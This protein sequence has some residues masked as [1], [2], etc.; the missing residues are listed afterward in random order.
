MY[1]VM[2]LPSGREI[3]VRKFQSGNVWTEIPVVAADV[4]FVAV[5]AQNREAALARLQEL[6][7]IPASVLAAVEQAK[8]VLRLAVRLGNEER[9]FCSDLQYA[10][11]KEPADLVAKTEAARLSVA[12]CLKELADA[13]GLNKENT[14]NE[15]N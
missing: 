5:D 2:T 1:E 4:A 9:R 11:T 8:G 6:V 7:A 15:K 14:C 12:E 10:L 13:V 3:R